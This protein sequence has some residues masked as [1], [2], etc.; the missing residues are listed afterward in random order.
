MITLKVCSPDIDQLEKVALFLLERKLTLDIN[1]IKDI[2]RINKV[3]GKIVSST[4]TEL[5]AKTK[6]LL[7]QEIDELIKSNFKPIPEIYSSPIIHMDWEQTKQL[8]KKIINI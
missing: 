7:F 4:V 3:D 8:S 5:N 6:A 2:T 1:I